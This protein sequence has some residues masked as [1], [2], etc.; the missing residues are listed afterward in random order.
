M[1]VTLWRRE[2]GP[3]VERNLPNPLRCGAVLLRPVFGAYL[4]TFPGAVLQEKDILFFVSTRQLNCYLMFYSEALAASLA[5]FGVLT[6]FVILRHYDKG[7]AVVA[8]ALAITGIGIVLSGTREITSSWSRRRYTYSD[9]CSPCVAQALSGS[10]ATFS[11][12]IGDS[13]GFFGDYCRNRGAY[14]VDVQ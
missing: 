12:D 6:V 13:L 14:W 5:I 2:P 9:G 4:S 10:S 7:F 3:A 11:A 1:E 8:S